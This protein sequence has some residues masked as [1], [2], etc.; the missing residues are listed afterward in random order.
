MRTNLLCTFTNKKEFR[1][2][3]DLIVDKYDILY[4]KIFLL[5][6]AE[7]DY[8]LMCTYNIS[9][10][11][12]YSELENTILLHRKKQT[13]TLYT[14]NALNALITVLNNGVLDTTYQL[15]WE[16]YRN[17]MLLTNEEGLKR[18]D[19]EVEDIIYIKVK[20]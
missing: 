7:N 11:E 18:I 10:E 4:N 16:L 14:I 20:R 12:N 1:K 8:N 17:T 3:I 9:V 5:R 15:D 13:N 19:T 6:E 2:V